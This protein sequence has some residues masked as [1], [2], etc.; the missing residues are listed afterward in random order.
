M[1]VPT[2]E[3][4]KLLQDL[5][6]AFELVQCVQQDIA[7]IVEENRQFRKF[8]T[9]LAETAEVPFMLKQEALELVE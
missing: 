6:E 3:Y 2:D 8:L 9:K 5:H 4:D 1:T 7:N